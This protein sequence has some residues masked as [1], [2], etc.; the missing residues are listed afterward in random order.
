MERVTEKHITTNVFIVHPEGDKSWAGAL[1]KMRA[2][3][4]DRG[5]DIRNGSKV[6]Q[7]DDGLWRIYELESTTTEKVE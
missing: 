1:G 6:L 4:R 2:I 7:G 3:S 5:S